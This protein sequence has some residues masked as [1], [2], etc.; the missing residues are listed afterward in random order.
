MHFREETKTKKCHLDKIDGQVKA[1]L[2]EHVTKASERQE[3]V[4]EANW[5]PGSPGVRS[6]ECPVS[7]CVSQESSQ[8]SCWT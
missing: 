5:S 3:S 1:A 2:S 8:N 4:P 6:E 7:S